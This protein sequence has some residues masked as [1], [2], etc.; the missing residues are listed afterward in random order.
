[1]DNP[2]EPAEKRMVTIVRACAIACVSRRTLY[3]WMDNGR[4][5]YLLTAGS[6]RRIDPRDLFRMP[7]QP[8]RRHSET[9]N[10]ML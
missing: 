9:P 5:P 2:I 8:P 3:N 10:P 6:Q 1:M 4:L 7:A